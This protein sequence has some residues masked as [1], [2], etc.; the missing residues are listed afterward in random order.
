MEALLGLL[1]FFHAILASVTGVGVALA[2][3]GVAF[4]AFG[5][6]AGART[7]TPLERHVR[8]SARWVARGAALAALGNLAHLGLTVLAVRGVSS[9]WVSALFEASFFR[10]DLGLVAAA[11]LCAAAA[12]ALAAG[13]A[14]S[15]RRRA[16]PL[17]AAL[18]AFGLAVGGAFTSH[19]EGR[20]AGRAPLLLLD[21]VHRTAAY[22]WLGG[23]AHLLL[24]G[25]ARP[26]PVELKSV[27][28]R[29]ATLFAACVGIL[30]VA[31]A[32]LALP[33]VG[34]PAALVG[35]SYGLLVLAK[36]VLLGGLLAIAAANHRTVARIARGE[37]AADLSLWRFAELEVGIGLVALFVAGTLAS[38]PPGVDITQLAKGSD[39]AHVFAQGW[40]DLVRQGWHAF[41]MGLVGVS[42]FNHRF[43]GSLLVA[44]SLLA[45]AERAGREL[46]VRGQAR[47]ARSLARWTRRLAS[48]ARNWP[49][50]L[51]ALGVFVIVHSERQA[52]P[53]G[54]IGFVASFT[55]P[56]IV[57]HRLAGLLVVGF[58]FFEWAVRTE[59]LRPS[60]AGLVFPAICLLGSGLLIVHSHAGIGAR[61]ELL[62]QVTH[63][64]IAILG[65][66]A[67]VARWLELRMPS[68][69]ARR[70]GWLWPFALLGIGLI[71]L[72]Y[73]EP[74]RAVP[75]PRDAFLA[76]VLLASRGTYCRGAHSGCAAYM[77]R[78][79]SSVES[80]MQRE[81]M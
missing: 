77:A 48:W 18:G 32:L 12:A 73:W 11:V 62:I 27:L 54:R 42:I 4:A 47:G 58:A 50:L 9:A 7:G 8:R 24:F 38:T 29:A 49:L 43:S 10:A 78:V 13:G 14:S 36:G 45:I 37:G 57:Q 60:R 69:Q 17:A 52:W 67:G 80:T 19:A 75:D 35:T 5:L 66:A 41:D 21:A 33:Y 39:V 23:V 63:L 25:E 16:A 26:N 31:G 64:P 70:I 51:L 28:P 2:L 15:G 59:R 44:M 81:R 1:D 40:R 61:D 30:V 76:P 22:A 53:F 34:T 68:P 20:L 74:P 3:G 72:G 71:L 65:V 55:D 6:G 56:E 46:W 79:R